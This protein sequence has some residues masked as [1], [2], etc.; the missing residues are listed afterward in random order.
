MWSQCLTC[1]VWNKTSFNDTSESSSH[2]S[3]C[4][5]KLL[6][7]YLCKTVSF[8]DRNDWVCLKEVHSEAESSQCVV[9]T[10]VLLWVLIY[11]HLLEVRWKCRT[12]ELIEMFWSPTSKTD[13]LLGNNSRVSH[14][15]HL[16]TFLNIRKKKKSFGEYCF[17]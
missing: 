1:S 5:F 17:K 7:I 15:K 16:K 3:E 14:F 10:V 2:G 12:A 6:V 13:N 4:D 11:C 9:F 8:E